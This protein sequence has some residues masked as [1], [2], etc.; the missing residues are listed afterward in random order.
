MSGET[1]F[2]TTGK[3]MPVGEFGGLGGGF[4]DAFLRNR[5]AVGVANQLAFRRGQ[6][7]ALVGF[8]RIENFANRILVR[9]RLG[10]HA[11]L[12]MRVLTLRN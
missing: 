3:P 4:G 1:I 6:A 9:A 10:R 2:I 8:D 5:N 7:G 12:L 11:F